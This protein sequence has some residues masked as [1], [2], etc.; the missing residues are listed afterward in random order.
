M[1]V[2][3]SALA[4]AA[5]SAE[6]NAHSQDGVIQKD[7]FM[8]A[9]FGAAPDQANFFADRVTGCSVSTLT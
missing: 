1:S 7:E 5:A 8:H 4:A 3:N 6:P 9:I 2:V